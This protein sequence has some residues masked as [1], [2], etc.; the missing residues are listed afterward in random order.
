MKLTN[1]QTVTSGEAYLLASIVD[2]DAQIVQGFHR[3][4]MTSIIKPGGIPSPKVRAL[5]AYIKTLE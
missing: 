1:G 5:I 3:G 2:P 4:V